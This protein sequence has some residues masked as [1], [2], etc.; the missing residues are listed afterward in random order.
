MLWVQEYKIEG[1]NSISLSLLN[2]TDNDV[3]FPKTYLR[4]QG[5]QYYYRYYFPLKLKLGSLPTCKDRARSLVWD[6]K[7]PAL[8]I[9]FLCTFVFT[10]KIFAFFSKEQHILLPNISIKMFL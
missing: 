1:V 6:W 4:G 8:R 10:I 5:Y 2:A 9:T 3:S 7:C